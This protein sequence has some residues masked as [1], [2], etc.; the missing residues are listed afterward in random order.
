MR[1]TQEIGFDLESRFRDGSRAIVLCSAI[2]WDYLLSIA[3]CSFNAQSPGSYSQQ[4]YISC[5]VE[6]QI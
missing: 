1:C 3:A 2:S 5:S 4:K 6:F